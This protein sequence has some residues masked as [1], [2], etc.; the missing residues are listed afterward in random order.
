MKTMRS[1]NFLSLLLALTLL[2]GSLVVFTSCANTN[3]TPDASTKA[4]QTQGGTAETQGAY[5]S[6]AKEKYGREFA[7]KIRD[8]ADE[9]FIAEDYDGD[10]LAS[11]I[12][13]R[14]AMV[15]DDF[16]ITLRV[17]TEEDYNKINQDILLQISGG[18]DDYDVYMGH[19]SSFTGIA[20]S[21]ALVDMASI[22]TMNL[23]A[24]YWDQACRENLIISG[25]NF[26]MTGDIDPGSMLITSCLVFNKSMVTDLKKTMPYEMVDNG[27][28]TIDAFLSEIKEVTF[29]LNGNSELS[30]EEDRFSLTGWMMDLPFSFFYGAG[31]KFVVINED[32]LPELSYSSE[33][34]INLYEKIYQAVIGEKSYY[35]T[36]VADYSTNY[37]VFADGRALYCD[38][39]LGKISQFLSDMTQDYG[40]VPIPKYDQYQ[41][42]YL[43]FVNGATPFMMICQTESDPE[44]VGAILDAMA[45]YNYDYVT[46]NMFEIATKLQ[47]A[48]DPDSSRMV[49]YIVHNRIYDF[50][51]FADLGISNIVWNNLNSKKAE[52]SSTIKRENSKSSRALSEL[53][54]KWSE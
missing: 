28:W 6:L 27:T 5:E 33:K 36:N 8:D 46:P 49:D 31:G 43:S 42:E 37:E 45:A 48:R 13:E 26:V 24:P 22:S 15:E 21:N 4:E 3:E 41:Q 16:G 1:V 38:I 34:V 10:L 19:K 14:N 51:Y 7:M 11:A 52:I 2:V 54:E 32:G 44:F 25:Q 30:Y 50:G 39:T 29:D 53:I 47:S 12:Y 40:I 9:E 35:V 17:D 20:Q 23:T 18:L